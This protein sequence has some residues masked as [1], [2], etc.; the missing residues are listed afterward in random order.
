[1]LFWISALLGA[2][3]SLSGSGSGVAPDTIVGTART[4]GPVFL[5]G[6]RVTQ[7]VLISDGDRVD[8]GPGGVVALNV[9][10]TDRLIVGERSSIRLR[11]SAS[12]VFAE[13]SSGRMQVNTSQQRL[14]EVRLTDE[15]I[16]INATSGL[17]HDYLVTRLTN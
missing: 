9:S 3:L 5:N 7:S 8:T 14:K 10:A 15:G 1:M 6:T 16:S 4:V 11:S 2:F 13:V 17:P 12:G